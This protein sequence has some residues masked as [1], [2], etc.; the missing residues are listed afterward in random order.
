[1]YSRPA[2]SDLINRTLADITSRLPDPNTLRRS[3][4]AVYARALAGVV[5]GLYGYIDWLSR[6]LI[7]D[8][9]DSDILE[10]WASIWG[11]TRNAAQA[12]TEIGRASCRERV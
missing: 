8:T 1:M 2:L 5:Q 4:A 12:A 6:Q 11:I 3:D 9:A 10:R 7:Y